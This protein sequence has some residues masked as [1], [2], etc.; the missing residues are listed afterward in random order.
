MPRGQ[1]SI[2]EIL[3]D[4]LVPLTKQLICVEL[5]PGNVSLEPKLKT[6]IPNKPMKPQRRHHPVALLGNPY[7]VIPAVHHPN[8]L[9]QQERRD[10]RLKNARRSVTVDPP[11]LPPL[12]EHGRKV[13]RD[14]IPLLPTTGANLTSN[15]HF[16]HYASAKKVRSNLSY[17]NYT[18]DGGMLLVQQ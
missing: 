13:Y 1:G 5:L 2:H 14:L 7:Q 3:H 9:H 18:Y 8:E 11:V 17:A 4:Q 15:D 16:E 6:G 12:N 10:L